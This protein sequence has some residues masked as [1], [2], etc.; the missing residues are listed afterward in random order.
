MHCKW[1]KVGRNYYKG[2]ISS[3]YL[4]YYINGVE[5]ASIIR[6]P[7]QLIDSLDFS[8]GVWEI[9]LKNEFPKFSDLSFK[10]RYQTKRMI[11]LLA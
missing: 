6:Q 4:H 3:E 7:I 11:E 10:K 9:Y 8:K 5:F 2:K 1:K